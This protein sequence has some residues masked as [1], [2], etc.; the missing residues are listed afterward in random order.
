MIIHLNAPVGG[1]Q[2][3]A[4]QGSW[5]HLEIDGYWCVRIMNFRENSEE[6]KILF[7]EM[8]HVE[9]LIDKFPPRLLHDD[10]LWRLSRQN[11]LNKIF[12]E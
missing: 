2:E 3:E 12:S 1:I 4:L 6:E 7:C 9:Q 11:H 10:M 5:F 8:Q